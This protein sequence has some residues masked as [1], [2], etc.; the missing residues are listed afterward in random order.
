MTHKKLQPLQCYHIFS[1]SRDVYLS[2]NCYDYQSR[3]D[4]RVPCVTCVTIVLK[5]GTDRVKV[6]PHAHASTCRSCGTTCHWAKARACSRKQLSHDSSI[7]CYR[8]KSRNRSANRGRK[9]DG[10]AAAA[11]V[12]GIPYGTRYDSRLP[13]SHHHCW[14]N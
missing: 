14:G 11:A 9:E 3:E 4:H 10:A 7:S 12:A 2:K 8:S 5:A 6:A 13:C 1:D